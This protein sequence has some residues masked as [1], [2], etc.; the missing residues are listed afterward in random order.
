MCDD[1]DKVLIRVLA[2]Y[3]TS[4]VS[5]L[6]SFCC[7]SCNRKVIAICVRVT[8]TG[9]SNDGGR[10]MAKQGRFRMPES[11]SHMNGHFGIHGVVP[12]RTWYR[13]TSA[14]YFMTSFGIT[15]HH[16]RFNNRFPISDFATTTTL[17]LPVYAA[18]S[19]HR[20]YIYIHKLYINTKSI[21]IYTCIYISAISQLYCVKRKNRL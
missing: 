1:E 16:S 3:Q 2:S 21:H 4:A 20:E 19:I 15:A 9:N 18:R 13:S 11:H 5:Y 8:F 7:D 6:C 14:Y 17:S 10:C 12:V